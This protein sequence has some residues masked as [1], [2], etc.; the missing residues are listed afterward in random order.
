MRKECEVSKG[1]TLA[2]EP[3]SEAVESAVVQPAVPDDVDAS[4]WDPGQKPGRVA[5]DNLLGE[6]DVK[7]MAA[8]EAA[9]K[10]MSA[11]DGKA[12]KVGG[13]LGECALKVP[14]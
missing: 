12:G 8:A 6:A 10:D 4:C 7:D 5:T 1:Q 3:E 13:R 14:S 11:G 9:E 2:D